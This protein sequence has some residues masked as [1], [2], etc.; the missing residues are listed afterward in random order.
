MPPPTKKAFPPTSSLPTEFDPGEAILVARI[1][2]P[3]GVAG[4][5]TVELFTDAPEQRFAAG[6]EVQLD[7]GSV[8][9]VTHFHLTA[10]APVVAFAGVT[11]RTAAEELR[12]RQLYIPPAARRPLDPDEFWP[13]E[14]E[15]MEVVSRSGETI[16]TASGVEVGHGQDRLLVRDGDREIAV[17]FVAE[18]VPQVDA[19]RRRIVVDLPEGLID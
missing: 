19:A 8:L 16:G 14:L 4:A 12:G 3:H 2:R 15:G 18:I 10:R 5:V 11:D 9:T 1:G 13:D 17:P 7:D 6:Q